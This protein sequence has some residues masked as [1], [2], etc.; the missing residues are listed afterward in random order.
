[1]KS[2]K[3]LVPILFFVVLSQSSCSKDEDETTPSNNPPITQI[4]QEEKDCLIFM[5]EEEKMAR[6]V[7]LYA[8]DLYG[9]Q[10]FSNIA[11]SEQTHMDKILELLNTYEISDP[12]SSEMGVFNNVDLQTL[13]NE[14]I[15]KCDSSRLDAFT[16]GATI[17]DVGLKDLENCS[18]STNKVDII[19]V[20]EN[21]SCGSRNHMRAF[22]GQI[23]NMG[24]S[25]TP[26][27]IAEDKYLAIIN[28]SQ[29][30]CGP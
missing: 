25:Y 24:G 8:F 23:D 6:D 1:M 2:L 22:S 14:L 11:N 5:R 29:E 4:T 19:T 12:A 3:Y 18:E 10:I 26:K 15:A 30:D 16:V 28:S 27:F 20:Y 7:Y 21:L 17:E 9:M 13:Y